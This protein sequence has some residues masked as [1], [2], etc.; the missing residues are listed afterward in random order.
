M[1]LCARILWALFHGHLSMIFLLYSYHWRIDEK[2]YFAQC[3]D[4]QHLATF[5][6]RAGEIKQSWL[7]QWERNWCVGIH[8]CWKEKLWSNPI[9]SYGSQF[10]GLEWSKPHIRWAEKNSFSATNCFRKARPVALSW[11]PR[12]LLVPQMLEE[13]L[14]SCRGKRVNED[15]KKRG[16][17]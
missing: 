7:R 1:Q 2:G 13:L 5:A 14:D 4:N 12:P 6:W 11:P 10:V 8:V 17:A 15:K 3:P 9:F 16:K